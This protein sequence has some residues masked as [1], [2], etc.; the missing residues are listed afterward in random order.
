M[1]GGFSVPCKMRVMPR[2]RQLLF[3]F[4]VAVGSLVAACTSG[5]KKAAGTGFGCCVLDAKPL[6]CTLRLG[7][8]KRSADDTCVDGYDGTN[9]DPNAP[10]WTQVDDKDGCPVWTP[11]PNVPTICCSCFNPDSGTDA[12]AGDAAND[13]DD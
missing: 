6:A 8:A 13:Q 2:Q 10:G 1:I 5:A 3:A 7:R 11:P 4:V 12:D 9:P